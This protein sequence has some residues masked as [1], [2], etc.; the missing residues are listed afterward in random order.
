MGALIDVIIPHYGDGQLT[1]KLLHSLRKYELEVRPIVIDNGP[2]FGL[3]LASLDQLVRFD[4]YEVVTN[5]RNQGFV[6]AVN[7]GFALVDSDFVVVQNNDTLFYDNALTRMRQHLEGDPK[8]GAI[9]P[10]AGRER[11][12]FR[13]WQSID[14]LAEKWPGWSALQTMEDS[15]AAEYLRKNH[16]GR[17]REVKGMLAFFCTMFRR[18]AL[19]QTGTLST[20]FGLGLGD[21]DDYCER[22]Q[23]A[24]WHLAL[25][26]GVLVG[27]VHRATFSQF[28]SYEEIKEQQK[29]ALE[30]FRERQQDRKRGKG[31]GTWPMS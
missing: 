12:G 24:G 18:E 13:S 8:L 19:A 23:M 25:A 31:P 14:N 16:A 28:Y 29:Q 17:V 2:D 26:E 9:G 21:D 11:T 15:Q 20:A 4:R 1:A 22:L 30:L 27:H 6:R 7:Q 5:T 10:V 3:S